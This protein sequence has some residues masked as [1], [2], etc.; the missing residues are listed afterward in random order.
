MQFHDFAETLLGSKV[1]V[2]LIRHLVREEGISGERETAKRIGVSH[3]AV[4]KTLEELFELNL[5]R[6]VRAG[7]VKIWYLNKES[8]A[9]EFLQSFYSSIGYSALE[10]L[11]KTIED[12]LKYLSEVRK[13]VIFGSIA[14]GNELSNSDVDLFVLVDSEDGRKRVQPQISSLNELCLKRYGNPL[15]PHIFTSRELSSPK[16]KKFLESVSKGITVMER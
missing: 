1:K 4:N 6:P 2:K 14:E 16:N 13:A 3:S 8:Y 7:N 15:S 11:K 10:Q 12:Y 5:V 9:Y